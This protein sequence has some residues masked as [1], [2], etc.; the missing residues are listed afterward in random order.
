M[1]FVKSHY[2]PDKIFI[3]SAIR[4]ERPNKKII[5][6]LLSPDFGPSGTNVSKF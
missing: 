5:Q 3:P 1:G 2:F 4:N 6:G